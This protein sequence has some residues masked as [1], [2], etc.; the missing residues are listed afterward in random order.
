MDTLTPLQRQL[1][2]V[3]LEE[4]L[5]GAEAARR[6]GLGTGAARMHLFRMRA[7]LSERFVALGGRLAVTPIGLL[8]WAWRRV[9]HA[10]TRPPKSTLV[11]AGGFAATSVVAMSLGVVTVALA[12]SHAAQAAGSR[13][14]I[15]SRNAAVSV[16]LGVV[17]T[18]PAARARTTTQHPA[19]TTVL[20][21]VPAQHH[22]T[23]SSTP[24]KAGTTLDATAEV[25]TPA[26]DL[27]I[28][29]NSQQD[30][31]VEQFACARAGAC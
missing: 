25:T 29:D 1:L 11:A 9:R 13:S 5:T 12:P 15:D 30:R 10:A 16:P 28:D 4:G 6:L 7:R 14:A 23:V 24:T 20:G 8:A 31:D 19:S 2:T 3:L 17:R 21:L 22:E 26:G 18:G 27:R